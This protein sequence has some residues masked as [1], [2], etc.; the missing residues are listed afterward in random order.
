MSV[1]AL[2]NTQAL[3][4]ERGRRQ[5]ARA[6][7]LLKGV[8]RPKASS[9]PIFYRSLAMML[10]CGI[11]MLSAFRSLASQSDD[12]VMSQACLG[13]AEELKAGYPLSKGMLL[14]PNI[15]NRFQIK[16]VEVGEST[17]KLD[18][19]LSR[20][21]DHEEKAH[22]TVLKVKSALT[23]PAFI[24]MVSMALLLIAPPFLF[25][26]IIPLIKSSGQ[27]LPLITRAVIAF[28][29]G[30]RNP[31][32]VAL[33]AVL[34]YVVAFGGSTWAA[35]PDNAKR[36]S[37][38]SLK[39]PVLGHLLRTVAVAR[40]S[41]AFSVQVKVGND[42]ISA[43]QMSAQ[44]TQNPILLRDVSK[45]TDAVVAGQP[46]HKSLEATGFFPKPF[47]QIVKVGEET[48][49][50]ATM[51]EHLTDMYEQD[52]DCAVDRFA[53]MVEP[54]IMLFMGTVVAILVVAM[55]LPLTKLIANL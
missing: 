37:E 14:Y 33:V 24:F 55:M 48:G 19:I 11:N 15:F 32:V 31:Y 41:R 22:A 23:Y 40:F 13:I 54:L 8:G 42:V 2:I 35:Q 5:E 12:L 7:N 27:E 38:H 45:A 50:V 4:N 6:L 43:L 18:E 52:I 47:L 30:V 16:L 46:L 44:S 25:S 29:E 28:S 20:L 53:A 36:I 39:I 10:R 34:A 17:G 1:E 3:A 49:E 51:I 26:G 9:I 21:A